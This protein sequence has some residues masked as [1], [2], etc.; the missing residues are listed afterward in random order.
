MFCCNLA[1]GGYKTKHADKK[2]HTHS[3]SSSVMQSEGGREGGREGGGELR[4][5]HGLRP[6]RKLGTLSQGALLIP[7]I[8]ILNPLPT[9]TSRATLRFWLA[10]GSLED[11][12]DGALG[13]LSAHLGTLKLL[14]N[15]ITPLKDAPKLLCWSGHLS[16]YD[17]NL[18]LDCLD[19]MRLAWSGPLLSAASSLR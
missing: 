17:Q 1:I 16:I 3:F 8:H 14:Q 15:T 10:R 18:I 19:L 2:S 4:L 13:P 12:V 6:S 11:P 7:S 5:S 9:N